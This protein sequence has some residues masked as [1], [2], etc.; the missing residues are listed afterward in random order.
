MEQKT[1]I[2]AEDGRQE[3]TVTRIFELPV[4]LLFKA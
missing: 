1:K 4:E 3:L 2:L